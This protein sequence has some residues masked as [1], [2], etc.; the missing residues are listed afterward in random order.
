MAG[1]IAL[2]SLAIWVYL[3]TARGGFWHAEVR[4]D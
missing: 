3:L 2:I 1:L 4:D